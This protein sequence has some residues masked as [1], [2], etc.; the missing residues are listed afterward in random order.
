VL[1]ANLTLA[2]KKR[3][4]IARALATGPRLLL[5]DEAASGIGR[6]ESGQ[7]QDLFARVR[8]Q[9]DLSMLVVEHD[10]DFV[11]GLCDYV[12]VLDFG[13]LIARG[14]PEVVRSDAQVIAAYLGE[15][16]QDAVAAG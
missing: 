8:R 7:L 14:T 11:L 15:E 6:E 10:V 5:L 12:Y 13:R 2:D 16:M 1:A 9:F 4:E 3:L